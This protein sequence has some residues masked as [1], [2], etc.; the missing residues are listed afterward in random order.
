MEQN[1]HVR[2]RALGAAVLLSLGMVA[3][4]APAQ[5]QKVVVQPNG[6]VA[7]RDR[8]VRPRSRVRGYRGEYYFSSPY[9]TY[10]EPYFDPYWG[11]FIGPYYSVRMGR[12]IDTDGD[13]V[14][15]RFDRHPNDLRRR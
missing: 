3:A 8:V 5:A 7:T 12:Y 13:G 6:A 14:P 2:A 11:P 15:D 1:T 10:Y 9:Y 4:T